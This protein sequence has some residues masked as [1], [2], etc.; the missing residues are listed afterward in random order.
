MK[1]TGLMIN[2]KPVVALSVFKSHLSMWL[3]PIF[4]LVDWSSQFSVNLQI[5]DRYLKIY[6]AGRQK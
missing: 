4:I 1:A 5:A 6:K 3:W 2:G